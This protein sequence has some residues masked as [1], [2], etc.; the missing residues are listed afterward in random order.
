VGPRRR[1][2]NYERDDASENSEGYEQDD[3]PDAIRRDSTGDRDRLSTVFATD[4][5]TGKQQAAW[6]VME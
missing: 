6:L 1:I 3:C 4:G 5:A 2:P